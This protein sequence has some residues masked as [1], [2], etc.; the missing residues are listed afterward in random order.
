MGD[1]INVCAF[2]HNYR[3]VGKFLLTCVAMC[4][5]MQSAVDGAGEQGGVVIKRL[6]APGEESSLG[7]ICRKTP[8]VQCF[9]VQ[10][11]GWWWLA[12]QLLLA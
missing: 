7:L 8:A 12:Q 11:T 3:C 2:D 9:A 1:P 10:C 6:A 5:A 4:I